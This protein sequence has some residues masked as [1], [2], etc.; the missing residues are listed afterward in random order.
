MILVELLDFFYQAKASK[1]ERN[2]GCEN[3]GGNKHPTVKNLSLTKYLVKLISREGQIVL[4]P[5]AGSGTTGMACK[6]M[7]RRFIGIEREAEYCEIA[8]CRI[9]SVK[10]Q[11]EEG[12]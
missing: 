12:A 7:G 11:K 10:G 1:R 9:K 4:D 2:M 8:K 3:I 6:K 5:F